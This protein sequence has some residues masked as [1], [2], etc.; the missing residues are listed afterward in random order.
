MGLFGRKKKEERI[1]GED[2]YDQEGFNEK[3]FDRNGIHKDTGTKFNEDGYDRNGIR[4]QWG[5]IGEK[6]KEKFT[7]SELISLKVLEAHTRHVGIGVASIDYD[8]MDTLG[9]STGDA[10]EIKGKRRTVARC[11]PLYPSDEGKG[12]IQ[13]DR[14]TRNNAGA[15]IDSDVVITKVRTEKANKIVL[16]TL[17][18]IP[19][20]DERYFS[21]QLVGKYVMIGDFIHMPYLGK[22]LDYQIVDSEPSGIPLQI[23]EKTNFYLSDDKSGKGT[24]Y[25]LELHDA[26]D[27]LERGRIQYSRGLFE[28]AIVSFDKAL[29]I[30][31][32]NTFALQG[33]AISQYYLKHYSESLKTYEQIVFDIKE[34]RTIHGYK[35]NSFEKN[36]YSIMAD[37]IDAEKY[38]LAL[39]YSDISYSIE[40]FDKKTLEFRADIFHYLERYIEAL[41]CH[42][43]FLEKDISIGRI[44]NNKG[45]MLRKLGRDE[46]SE[47]CF[48]KAKELG[49]GE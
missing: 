42:E 9:A 49:Y 45:V 43:K 16:M 18:E 7:Y 29:S 30:N 17:E 11:H 44:W 34:R 22:G 3:G 40:L 31:E 14:N 24:L 19:P 47:K 23:T 38:D 33:K 13:M 39:S 48:A 15:T 25:D 27:P 10:I 21:G 2:G 28:N 20:L 35:K 37:L 8:S 36:L 12:I 5:N 46:E 4:D 32:K 6:R 1:F 41:E 26:K